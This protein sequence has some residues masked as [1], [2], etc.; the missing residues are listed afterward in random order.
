MKKSFWVPVL[1]LAASLMFSMTALAGDINSAEQKI[2]DAISQ[3]YEYEG[4]YY[5]VTDAYIARVIEELSKDDMNLSS[6][7]A[8]SYIRQ[9]EMNLEAGIAG[10]YMVKVGDVESPDTPAEEPDTEDGDNTGDI[11]TGDDKKDNNDNDDKENNGDTKTDNDKNL[12]KDNSSKEDS[13]K[14][15]SS[16]EKDSKK[17]DASKEEDSEKKNSSTEGNSGTGNSSTT[18]TSGSS[19]KTGTAS[20]DNPLG[21][22]FA[23]P[24]VDSKTGELKDNTI[25]S[26]TDGEIEYTVVNIQNGVTMYI[27]DIDILEV[28]SEAYKDSEVIGTLNKGD[29]V[30]VI[31]AATTGWAQIE[32]GDTVGYI[33]AVYLRT[34]TFMDTID[35]EVLEAVKD[36]SNAAPLAKSL[37]LGVL[38]LVVAL[39]AAIGAGGIILWHRTKI[40]KR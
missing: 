35:E 22:F 9:F 6:S 25:G 27:W 20:D 28:H 34:Q 7:E 16:K 38:A 15:S 10:G 1:T 11:G 13:K 30:V 33:S 19:A 26:T 5:R 29:A 36:Y 17:D 8:R 18:G 2:I 40:N 3:T 4:A 12:G 14:D 31:G 37:N 32:Y 23:Q 21:S 39:I 24:E